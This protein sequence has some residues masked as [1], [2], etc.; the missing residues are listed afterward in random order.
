MQVVLVNRRLGLLVDGVFCVNEMAIGLGRSLQLKEPSV[1]GV[2]FE[3][4]VSCGY[5]FFEYL[6]GLFL[7]SLCFLVMAGCF[8]RLVPASFDLS[9]RSYRLVLFYETVVALQHALDGVA[10]CVHCDTHDCVFRGEE[11][12]KYCGIH[13]KDKTCMVF[14]GIFDEKNH[15]WI[16]HRSALYGMCEDVLFS[17]MDI[18][19]KHFLVERFRGPFGEACVS[20]KRVLFKGEGEK[21]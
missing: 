10:V 12:G 11:V 2:I 20:V 21:A 5:I 17:L 9:R 7:E 1:N 15:R 4:K 8:V 6:V 16:T 18:E 19:G 13:G 14:H 3:N